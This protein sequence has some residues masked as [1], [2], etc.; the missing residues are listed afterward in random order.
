VIRAFQEVQ[1]PYL[2]KKQKV[3]SENGPLFDERLERL[4]MRLTTSSL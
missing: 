2:N 4:D 1:D 3:V